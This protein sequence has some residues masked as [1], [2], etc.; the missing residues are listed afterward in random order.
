MNQFRQIINRKITKK[1]RKTKERQ[2]KTKN[3]GPEADENC[4]RGAGD[5]N[6]AFWGSTSAPPK[7]TI[8][9]NLLASN[10]EQALAV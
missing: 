2:E 7:N 3:G 10:H 9:T 5:V 4:G 8:G 1:L 6:G